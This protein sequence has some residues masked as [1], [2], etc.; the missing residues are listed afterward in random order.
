MSGKIQKCLLIRQDG[1][2]ESI[3]INDFLQ[4]KNGRHI[5]LNGLCYLDEVLFLGMWCTGGNTYNCHNN[6]KELNTT[7]STIFRY[8]DQMFNVLPDED[9]YKLYGN[10]L[11]YDFDKDMTEDTWKR[12]Q[13]EIDCKKKREPPGDVDNYIKFAEEKMKAHKPDDLL[14][15]NLELAILAAK[16]YGKVLS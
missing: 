11:L 4:L 8:M 3:R 13:K 6:S 16:E 5:I 15:R 9:K 12:I 1:S 2:M 10:I 14:Y 7:A